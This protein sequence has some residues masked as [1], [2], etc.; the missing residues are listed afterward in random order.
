MVVA[1]NN[2]TTTL[3]MLM[4]T[5]TPPPVH[6]V[7]C[8]SV[9]NSFSLSDPLYSLSPPPPGLTFPYY[10]RPILNINYGKVFCLKKWLTGLLPPRDYSTHT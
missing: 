2:P 10:K 3:S 6:R 1:A 9:G 8:A 5:T 4:T 7:W